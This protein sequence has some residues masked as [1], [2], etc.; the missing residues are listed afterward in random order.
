M[1]NFP[2]FS[3]NQV[4]LPVTEAHVPLSN[5]EYSYGFGV[6]E[7]LRV[8]GGV[9]YFIDEHI[10]RLMESA[11]IIGIEHTLNAT[12]VARSIQELVKK[13]QVDSC[14]IKILLIGGRARE[15]TSL[16]VQCLNPLYPDRKLYRTGAHF[17]TY[18]YERLFPHAKS[19]NMLSSYLAYRDAQKVGA[20]DALLVN[21]DGAILEGTRT[22]FFCIKDRTIFS[23]SEDDILL[24]V[25]RKVVLKVAKDHDYEIIQGS[26][27]LDNLDRFDG[28]FVTSTS[29]KIMPARSIDSHVFGDPPESLTELIN[30]LQ[31]F[32]QTCNGTLE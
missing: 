31:Q 5:I 6:Y 20:Y 19:L 27:P 4:L 12:S 21:Q 26:I 9:P 28:A 16:Y 13:N 15:D 24:G 18:N 30:K 8:T 2:Y 32:L 22:N 25:M 7:T 11:R 1:P 23:P 14:N 3:H 10:E 29:S 17:I